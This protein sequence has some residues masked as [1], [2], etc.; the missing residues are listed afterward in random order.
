MSSPDPAPEGVERGPNGK[1]DD[2]DES[3]TRL[4]AIGRDDDQGDHHDD[5]DDDHGQH[6]QDD[7]HDD[8]EA[9][10]DPQDDSEQE[11][12]A[13]EES[14]ADNSKEALAGSQHRESAGATPHTTPVRNVSTSPHKL[15][16]QRQ[17]A[18]ASH[19]QSDNARSGSTSVHRTPGTDDHRLNSKDNRTPSS[20]YTN[21][22]MDAFASS[23]IHST[24]SS[25]YSVDS[26]SMSTSLSSSMSSTA[27]WR[28]GS[29]GS[30]TEIHSDIRS[31][32]LRRGLSASDGR[33]SLCSSGSQQRRYTPQI[34]L[35]SGGS[36]RH[37]HTAR[38]TSPRRHA[39]G[40]SLQVLSETHAQVAHRAQSL[41][42]VQQRRRPRSSSHHTPPSH[43][44]DRSPRRQH[45]L[46]P[47][48][49][50][51]RRSGVR[52]GRQSPGRK[53]HEAHSAHAGIVQREMELEGLSRL[54]KDEWETVLDQPGHPMFTMFEGGIESFGDEQRVYY[55][56]IIDFLVRFGVR[57]RMESTFKG[58]RYKQTAISAVA[59]HMYAARFINFFDKA[60]K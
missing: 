19:T 10:S 58:I 26:T 42:Q 21:N 50:L 22:D 4:T 41:T 59:P 23:P 45:V 43:K 48:S 29:R 54:E 6:D 56:G 14:E 47:S 49:R 30:R 34:G 3:G 9:N 55:L 38:R 1:G 32:R 33:L 35:P 20:T 8:K 36:K 16:P 15:S 7:E 11:A 13:D 39:R 46:T 51:G 17:Q 5:R 53:Q 18:H 24:T 37:L 27:G 44:S 2:G 25:A 52:L 31:D 60:I 28:D 12:N 57:K 40:Q